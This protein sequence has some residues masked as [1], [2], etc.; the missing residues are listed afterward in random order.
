MPFGA[1]PEHGERVVAHEDL[2]SEEPGPA[3][4]RSSVVGRQIGSREAVHAQVGNWI[5]EDDPV[6]A[7][8]RTAS[9]TWVMC[10]GPPFSSNSR[11]RI[12]AAPITVPSRRS[13]AASI[14][15][16]PPSTARS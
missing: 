8:A 4:A 6:L 10:C 2:L 12:L 14:F 7:G 15:E 9:S 5:V 11:V 3:T 16:P 1:G 13:R